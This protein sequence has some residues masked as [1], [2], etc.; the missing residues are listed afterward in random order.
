MLPLGKEKS[1]KI[2]RM[3]SA[4]IHD[5]SVC[6]STRTLRDLN[7]LISE[8]RIMTRLGR[9]VVRQLRL[10]RTKTKKQTLRVPSDGAIAVVPRRVPSLHPRRHET[11]F[12][13]KVDSASFPCRVH[14]DAP[15][16]EKSTAFLSGA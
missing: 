15:Y 11:K 1:R 8:S 2:R 6:I 10:P 14:P 3:Q 9:R 16:E 13:N 4:I 7:V 5:P 12:R